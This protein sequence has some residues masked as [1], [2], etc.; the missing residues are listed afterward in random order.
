MVYLCKK[1]LVYIKLISYLALKNKNMRKSSKR[2]DNQSLIGVKKGNQEIVSFSHYNEKQR[3]VFNIKCNYC[4]NDYISTI[5]NFRDVRKSGNSCQK[6]SNIQNKSYETLTMSE[7]QFG[8]IY[9]NYKSRAKSKGIEFTLDK[10]LFKNLI[11]SNCHYCNSEPN[12][13]RIDRVKGSREIDNSFLSNGIDRI[14]SSKGYIEGN[15]L[16][17]C[18]DCNKAKR[19]LS[20]SQFLELIKDIYEN[21]KLNK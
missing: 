20:Y 18:E 1:R 11:F 2:K 10:N 21:L 9:S 6:C 19:N 3:R 17:C 7:S 14:D 8:I 16:S 13:F 4:N 5:E 15:L 12:K